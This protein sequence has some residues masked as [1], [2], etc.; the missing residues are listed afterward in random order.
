[1][2]AQITHNDLID[3]KIVYVLIMKTKPFNTQSNNHLIPASF[4]AAPKSNSCLL[5]CPQIVY[6]GQVHFN[7]IT[8]P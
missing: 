1:M 7:Y 6:I 8:G 3:I 2:D 5:I 4:S